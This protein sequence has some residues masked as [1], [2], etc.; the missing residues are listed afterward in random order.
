M[1]TSSSSMGARRT[2]THGEANYVGNENSMLC[3]CG[4]N[5][6][7]KISKQDHSFGKKFFTCPNRRKG[8]GGCNF[9]MWYEQEAEVEDREIAFVLRR[10]ANDVVQVKKELQIGNKLLL[11]VFVMLSFGTHLIIAVD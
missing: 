3:E 10:I 8:V 9:F 1:T 7:L 2:R 5:V 4:S 11:G 6:V